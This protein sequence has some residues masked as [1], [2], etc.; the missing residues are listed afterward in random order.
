M[1]TYTGARSALTQFFVTNWATL[2]PTI[3]V[4]YEN[5]DLVSP[6]NLGDQCMRF[7]VTFLDA[8]QV[9]MG[10][11]PMTR[12]FGQLIVTH[13]TKVG[14]GT[15]IGLGHLESLVQTFRYQTISTI[16]VGTPKFG[17]KEVEEGWLYQDL[18]VPFQFHM[19]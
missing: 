4:L 15:N 7:R 18:I 14:Q 2:N 1:N 9:E 3:K 6:D 10:D 16:Q 17:R 5:Q 8:E 19:S 13:Y 12:V 11:A